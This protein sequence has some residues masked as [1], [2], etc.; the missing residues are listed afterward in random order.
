LYG[1]DFDFFDLE[2]ARLTV[3]VSSS[4]EATSY[5]S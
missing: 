3:S 5:P 4:S 1:I 2:V